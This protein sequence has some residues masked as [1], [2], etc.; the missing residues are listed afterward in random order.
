MNRKFNASTY[1]RSRVNRKFNAST[2]RFTR[3][4]RKFN[5][6]LDKVSPDGSMQSAAHTFGGLTGTR[7]LTRG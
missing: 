5:A 7:A 3:V 2:R 1:R 6:L 4:N